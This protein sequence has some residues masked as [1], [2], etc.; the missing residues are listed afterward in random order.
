MLGT[1]VVLIIVGVVL[2]FVGAGA[3]GAFFQ[4]TLPSLP[5]W[6]RVVACGA[7]IAIFVI[8]FFPALY[9][10]SSKQPTSSPPTSA[11]ATLPVTTAPQVASTPSITPGPLH[12]AV[13][14]ALNPA[15]V[16]R[17][18]TVQLTY[19]IGLNRPMQAGLGAGLYD[20]QGNDHSNGYG[21]ID[22][23]FLPAGNTTKTRPVVI[24]A[25]L[26][27][28]RYELDAEVWPPNKVG[29]NGA[30]T[31]GSAICSYFRVR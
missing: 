14:C 26:A 31:R 15:H 6:A 22:S 5:I 24:P 2:V 17:G 9:G 13:N 4:V 11:P 3:R 23:V 18:I 30:N 27:P 8:S 10:G 16:H 29:A 28:G 12:L 25:S 1:Q 20:N 7:G 21:D 19:E